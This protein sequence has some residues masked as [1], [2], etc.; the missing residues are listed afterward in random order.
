MNHLQPVVNQVIE[1]AYPELINDHVHVEFTDLEN[2]FTAYGELLT[3]GFFIELDNTLKEAS[4][5]AIE[6]A[7]AREL[8]DIVHDIKGRTNG[9]LEAISRAIS[10]QYETL[11]ERN[12]DLD[13]II[14][15]YGKQ[16][17]AFLEFIEIQDSGHESTNGLS[18]KEVRKILQIPKPP[19]LSTH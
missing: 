8:S 16:L 4:P 5:E 1:N 13:V 3:K 19:K 15:G 14:R 7:I 18:A 11:E 17:L 2:A 12:I 10:N 9:I 6:G